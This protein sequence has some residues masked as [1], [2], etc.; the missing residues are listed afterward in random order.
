MFR[1]LLF[2]LLIAFGSN[3]MAQVTTKSGKNEDKK[4]DQPIDYKAMGAPMPDLHLTV[5]IDTSKKDNPVPA[6]KSDTIAQKSKTGRKKKKHPAIENA[7][8]PVAKAQKKYLTNEDFDNGA[9]L[10]VMMFNPTC[11]HCEDE[12]EL[13]EKNIFVFKK[14]KIIL[15]ANQMMWEYIPNFAKSFHVSEYPTITIGSDSSFI[16]KVFLY[17]ALPQINIY[18]TKRKL[19]KTFTGEVIIDSLRKYIE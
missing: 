15:L 17:Q 19:I 11:S 9:N 10:M 6:A 4:V 3:A 13:L 2:L 7:D 16:N 18:N 1:K 5:Y 8:A 12:T 14:T